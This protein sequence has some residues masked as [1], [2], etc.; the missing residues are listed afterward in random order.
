MKT[1][2]TTNVLKA[3]AGCGKTVLSAELTDD[4]V[5]KHSKRV[6][7]AA[8]THKAVGVLKAKMPSLEKYGT[9]VTLS[10]IHSILALK[11]IWQEDQE[12]WVKNP[13]KQPWEGDILIVDE[14]SMNDLNI[15]KRIV[16]EMKNG[17]FKHLLMVGDMYQIEPV[18]NDGLE[19]YGFISP[20]FFMKNRFELSE[21]VRQAKDSPIISL[22]TSVRKMQDA[23]DFRIPLIRE[24][25]NENDEGVRF[26]TRQQMF[27]D[28]LAH[29]TRDDYLDNPDVY[30]IVC[31]TNK[32]VDFFNKKIREAIFK[33][34]DIPNF[35]EGEIIISQGTDGEDGDIINNMEYR[36]KECRYVPAEEDMPF[37]YWNLR[38][39]ENK[40]DELMPLVVDTVC[41]DWADEEQRIYDAY[42]QH[43]VDEAKSGKGSWKTFYET[44]SQFVGF[45]HCYAM[46]AHKSQGSTFENTAVFVTDIFK[47]GV[48]MSSLR[49][50]YTAITRSSKVTHCFT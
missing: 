22:A 15:V 50:F 16:T 35:M 47:Y 37:A 42:L 3:P 30:R 24:D 41:V 44:K 18:D 45:K 49:M 17:S 11:P 31:Y 48:D 33:T 26:I 2:S 28:A 13:K 43:L 19:K 6:A 10:T 9:Y 23:K 5:G 8:P 27:K 36:I 21:I 46:T 40:P 25:I 32:S 39:E 38:L 20:S 12:V 29:M 4:L 34:T 7:I 14:C 1:G